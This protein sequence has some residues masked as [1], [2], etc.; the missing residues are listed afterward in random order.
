MPKRRKH[1]SNAIHTDKA[2]EHEI[3]QE[4]R[5]PGP[6]QRGAVDPRERSRNRARSQTILNPTE[7]DLSVLPAS[8]GRPRAHHTDI[9][10]GRGS[11]ASRS[12]RVSTDSSLGPRTSA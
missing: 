12:R 2:K 6:G 3:S 7:E 10:D 5:Q 4:L 9:E 8:D 11:S 1:R